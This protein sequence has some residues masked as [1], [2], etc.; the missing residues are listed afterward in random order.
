M[1]FKAAKTTETSIESDKLSST[2]DGKGGKIGTADK[3]TAW[4]LLVK[5]VRQHR[6]N[7]GRLGN[8]FDTLIVK[9]L[10]DQKPSFGGRHA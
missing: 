3:C 10:I 8:E 1:H 7:H 2:G 9:E 5:Q 4:K 6:I